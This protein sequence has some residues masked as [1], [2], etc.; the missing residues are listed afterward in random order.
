MTDDTAMPGTRGSISDNRLPLLLLSF[1]VTAGA[2]FRFNGIG[3]SDLWFDEVFTIVYTTRDYSDLWLR[4]EDPSPP[5]YYTLHKFFI[6][7]SEDPAVVRSLSAVFGV[8]AIPVMYGLCASLANR[9]AGLFGAAFLAVCS[10]H[11]Q[12]SQEARAYAL[13]FLLIVGSAYGLSATLR[14]WRRPQPGGRAAQAIFLG[15]AVVSVYTHYSALIWLGA[16]N[17]VLWFGA[18]AGTRRRQTFLRWAVGS[19]WSLIAIVPAI[20]MMPRAARDFTWL[21]PRDIWEAL[22]TLQVLVFPRAPWTG[23]EIGAAILAAALLFGIFKTLYH[24]RAIPLILAFCLFAYFLWA[25]QIVKPVFM[26]R[27]ALPFVI[28]P[29]ALLALAAA[30][31]PRRLMLP[32]AAAIGAALVASH[33]AFEK[34]NPSRYDWREA[35]AF[36]EAEVQ[37]GDVILLCPE[38]EYTTLRFHLSDRINAPIVGVMRADSA[39]LFPAPALREL[40]WFPGLLTEWPLVSP[41]E[42]RRTAPAGS[43]LWMIDASCPAVLQPE[44]AAFAGIAGQPPEPVWRGRRIEIRTMEF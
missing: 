30:S 20:G 25:V 4:P 7:Y 24:R 15:L 40:A 2:F 35:A 42:V 10:A 39:R 33:L 38:V 23:A 16:A 22:H 27:T 44:V 34:T 11:I 32:G 41:A 21:G 1:I 26:F 6:G 12:Y 37:D 29:L 14:S 31:L 3:S 36:I 8:A 5:L 13:L 9:R 19:V 43:R 28:A 18:L 17:V